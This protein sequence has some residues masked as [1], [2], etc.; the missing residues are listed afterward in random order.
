MNRIIAVS[1]IAVAALV[2]SA[3]VSAA[4]VDV[5][6]IEPNNALPGA[7]ALAPLLAGQ[8]GYRVS[9]SRIAPVGAVAN[10]SADYYAF[11]A[12]AGAS[13]NLEVLITSSTPPSDRDSLLYLY[14]A[15]GNVLVFDD[16]S[17]VDFGSRISAFPLAGG[18]YFVGVSGFGDPGDLDNG[19]NGVLTGVGG[20]ANFA[21]LLT[22]DIAPQVIPLPGSAALFVLGASM[23]AGLRKRRP[24]AGV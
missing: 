19:G 12:P 7:Q 5:A 21:Y 18:L 3:G 15:G 4:L 1:L 13:L 20:D 16:N 23:L 11:N 9:G 24:A 6:E 2:S 22:I 17:G 14:G 8:T 10:D